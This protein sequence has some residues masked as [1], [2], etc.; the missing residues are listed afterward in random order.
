MRHRILFVEQFYYPDGWGGAE[1]PVDLTIHLSRAGFD[2]EVI[3]GADQYAPVEGPLPSSIPPGREF[4]SGAFRA[5]LSG[6]A[7]RG[8]LLRQVWFY[9]ALLPLLLLRRPR[10]YPLL[11]T[12]PPLSVVLVAAASRIWR[13]PMIIIAMDVYPE[14]LIAHG[15]RKDSLL[16]ASLAR[17]FGWPIA[18][19]GV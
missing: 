19:H 12:N 6:V 5:L 3:C 17:A 7:H 1:L 14:V 16:G 10:M 4:V 11:Q 8:K 15:L 9:A 18:L 2:V 13:K